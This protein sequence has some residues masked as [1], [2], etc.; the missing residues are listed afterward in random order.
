MKLYRSILVKNINLIV[1]GR[2]IMLRRGREF[3]T[4]A[5]RNRKVRVYT[6]EWQKDFDEDLFVGAEEIVE[7]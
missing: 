4:S 5:E 1:D 2:T 6:L 7:L 3:L